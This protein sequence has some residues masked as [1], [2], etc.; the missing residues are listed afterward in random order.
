MIATILPGSADF[1]AVGYNEHKVSKG[2]ARLIEMRNFGTVGLAGRPTTEELT[3]YLKKYSSTNSRIRKP[4]FHVAVSCKGH[5]MTESELLDFAHRYLKEMGYAEPGQPWLIYAHHDTDNTHLHIITSRVAPDGRKIAHS[6]ER[7]RSQEVIDRILGNDRKK[8]TEDD[9]DAARQYTF[10]SFAQFKAIMVSMGY[11]VYKKDE[12]VFIK[13][14]GKVQR[15]IPLSDVES[16]YKN[17]YRNRARCRQLRSI[18]KKYRDVS[19]G[20]EELQKEVKE[21]FGIPRQAGVAASLRG[22]IE[23][24]APYNQPDALRGLEE[25]DY[26]WLIWGFSLNPNTGR[27]GFEA[28]VRPPRLGG[29]RRIGVFA[30]R[31]PFRP[32][33]LGLSSV[34]IVGIDLQS[35]RIEVAGADLADGTPIYDI[36]PYVEYADSHAGVRSGFVDNH[37][38]KTLKVVFPDDI[39]DMFDDSTLKA[40]E[41]ILAQDPRPQFQ[42]DPERVYGMNFSGREIKFRVRDDT[43][44]VL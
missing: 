12:N 27:Q 26:L 42:H 4:Q 40:L 32:N 11:E 29:N 23:L 33:G 44:E 3:G 9:I 39:G 10:S 8:K 6:H 36:K 21:K 25:F 19:G 15:Q 13:H 43:L 16:L 35:C 37:R 18:L 14:G 1:H 34:R 17:T 31:S 2:L 30:S 22:T 5:E 20:K 28:T 24:A 41:E 7:R 38:W